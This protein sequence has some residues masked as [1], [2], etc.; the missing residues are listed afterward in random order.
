MRP[1]RSKKARPQSVSPAATFWN[2]RLRLCVATY[3]A[4]PFQRSIILLLISA[5]ASRSRRQSPL[6]CGSASTRSR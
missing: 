5:T 2:S 3:E 6:G 1:M 4:T